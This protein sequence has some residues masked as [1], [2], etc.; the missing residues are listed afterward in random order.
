M[1][2]TV[3]MITESVQIR[4]K[5]NSNG[6]CGLTAISSQS[7]DAHQHP[8]WLNN[9]CIAILAL[10]WYGCDQNSALASFMYRFFYVR[11]AHR[12]TP[13]TPASQSDAVEI[14][15]DDS[16][17]YSI[18]V[19]A[20]LLDVE[21]FARALRR[22]VREASK[23]SGG[24]CDVVTARV[25]VYHVGQRDVYRR[26]LVGFSADANCSDNAEISAITRTLQAFTSSQ[27]MA[28]EKSVFLSGARN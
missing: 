2:I 8:N 11:L 13:C 18:C 23:C 7:G 21:V 5:W 1:T 22:C 4:L 27:P 24:S 10:V 16:S 15:V 3:W 25:L 9:L 19:V 12:E 17:R 28:T 20:E 26:A 14:L 6:Q